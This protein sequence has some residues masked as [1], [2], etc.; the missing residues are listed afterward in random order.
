MAGAVR[1]SDSISIPEHEIEISAVRARGAGGQNVNKVSTAIHLRFDIANS[2]ALSDTLKRRLLAIG[3]SRV[4]D[5]GVLVI[6]SQ[7]TRSRE[8]NRQQAIDRLTEFV[9]R[10]LVRRK[11]RIP[12]RPTAGAKQARLD[13]KH[14]RSALK[15]TRGRV[16]ED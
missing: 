15:K 16:S 9:Q 10:G 5:S 13:E 7:K 11:R 1:I 2:A 3:D 8:R 14:R 12:T 6:K 4:S